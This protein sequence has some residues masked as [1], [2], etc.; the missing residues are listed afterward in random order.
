[1]PIQDREATAETQSA[2][3]DR[4]RIPWVTGAFCSLCRLDCSCVVRAKDLL[5]D[6]HLV[7]RRPARVM[8]WLPLAS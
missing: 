6:R 5:Q 3:A 4:N 7:G 1:M 2:E 8:L